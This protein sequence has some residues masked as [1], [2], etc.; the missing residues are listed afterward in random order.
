[1]NFDNLLCAIVPFLVRTTT[2][3]SPQPQLWPP[4]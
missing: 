2:S 1:M 3:H 4:D